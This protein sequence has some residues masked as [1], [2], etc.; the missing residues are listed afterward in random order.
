M[1]LI[2]FSMVCREDLGGIGMSVAEACS[3]SGCPARREL[4][5]FDAT[6][7]LVAGAASGNHGCCG[8]GGG[9]GDLR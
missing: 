5:A 7:S 2:A 8:F 3:R 4:G 1:L 9:V 6:L